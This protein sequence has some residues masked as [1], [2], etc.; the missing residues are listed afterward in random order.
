MA[1]SG[2]EGCACELCFFSKVCL[3]SSFLFSLSKAPLTQ[4]NNVNTYDGVLIVPGAL[5]IVMNQEVSELLMFDGANSQSWICRK[6]V[7]GQ[8]CLSFSS[9]FSPVVSE[10]GVI[11]PIRV[12]GKQG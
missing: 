1:L 6:I 12:M 8:R 9:P 2:T 10:G 11:L 5:I 4:E 3:F 7:D